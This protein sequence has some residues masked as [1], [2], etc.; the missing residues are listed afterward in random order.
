MAIYK[1]LRISEEDIDLDGLVKYESNSIQNQ[2]AYLDD[3]IKKMPEFAGCE[4]HEALDD[5]RTGTNFDRPGVQRLIELA[6][7]GK[8][9]CIVVKDLSRWGRSYLDV[10]DFLEQKF[11]EWGVRF[12][13]INDNYDSAAHS[14]ATGGIDLAFKNLIYD[15]Y[16]QDLSEKVRSGK[17]TAA[18]SGSI[19]SAYPLYGYDK[20]KND[21]RRLVVDPEDSLIVKRIFDLAKQGNGVADIVLSG[22]VG[23]LRGKE[24]VHR[25]AD[26]QRTD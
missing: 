3:F 15:L 16:S 1:Y 5:G 26:A 25:P 2:R 23:P 9:D 22:H 11:P 21:K 24:G 20:D 19:T 4:V 6:K 10:G 17:D 12:I 14:G 8:V 13:S 18:K 7:V